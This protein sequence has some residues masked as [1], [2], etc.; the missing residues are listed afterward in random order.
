MP[1]PSDTRPF[2]LFKR[3]V[4]AILKL[5]PIHLRNL[6]KR[7]FAFGFRNSL[8][9]PGLKAKKND[10]S[11]PTWVFIQE[12]KTKDSEFLRKLKLEIL[13]VG[14]LVKRNVTDEDLDQI[15]IDIPDHNRVQQGATSIYIKQPITL[16]HRWALPIDQIAEY[17]RQRAL[18]YIFAPA[19]ICSL[20][21]AASE[22]LIYETYGLEFEQKEFL[23]ERIE[24]SVSEIKETLSATEFYQKTPALK[25][26]SEY[27]LMAETQEN[28]SIV[29]NNLSE[30]KSFKGDHVTPARVSAFLMQFPEDLQP[31][32][33]DL[34]TMLRVVDP[35]IIAGAMGDE[36][37]RLNAKNVKNILLAPIGNL[38]DS[39]THLLYFLKN[40]PV[41]SSAD[42]PTIALLNDNTIASAD[43]LI[44][45]D[46]NINSSA[47][48]LNILA[49][50]LGVSLPQHLK[51]KEKHVAALQEESK[52]KLRSIPIHFIYGVGPRSAKVDLLKVLVDYMKLDEHKV[53]ITLCQ[54][55]DEHDKPLTGKNSKLG[56]K[57]LELREFLEKVGTELLKSSSANLAVA[58][59]RALGYSGTE[60]LVLL[61][62]N[63][64]SMTIAALW[65]PG[66][67]EGI[68]WLPLCERRRNWR[69]D[70]PSDDEG[71]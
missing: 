13:K 58:N 64:P 26:K 27:L 41:L 70:G 2:E 60:G 42:T 6:L 22:K 4:A 15:A 20:V 12:L 57:R 65:C 62:Y 46:D 45:F 52:A 39:A 67:F 36:C 50:W 10:D 28:L 8:S 43:Y 3:D 53:T 38:T 32:A 48:T 69:P 44:L 21:A 59:K 56:D 19:S 24:K 61:Q 30:F 7:A 47:Q 29:V 23:G 63:V 54:T 35:M 49:E 33:L 17:Y 31:P 5:K 1:L 40:S 9:E 71:Q 37:K 34:L 25:V 51:L 16:P 66:I 11:S 68:D 18:S 55:L 14:R